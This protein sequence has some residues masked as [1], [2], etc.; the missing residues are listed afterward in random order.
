MSDIQFEFKP[1]EAELPPAPSITLS[2]DQKV[3]FDT[4]VER[5]ELEGEVSTLTGAAGCGKTTLMRTLIDHLVHQGRHVKLC[6]PTG[7]AAV[8]LSEVTGRGCETM[9][10]ALYMKVLQGQDKPVFDLPGPPCDPGDIVIIDEASMVARELYQEFQEWVPYESHVVYVGDKEQLPPV[11]DTWG[12]DLDNASAHLTEIHRQ[13]M[14]NPIIVFSKAVREGWDDRWEEEHF[15]PDDPRIQ[16][17]GGLNVAVDWLLDQRSR[18]EDAT[19]ITYTHN[20]RRRMNKAVRQ[21]LGLDVNMMSVGDKLVV[22]ANNPKVG[23]MNGEV[24]T[25]TEVDELDTYINFRVAESPF[26]LTM[27]KDLLEKPRGEFYKDTRHLRKKIP[28][29]VHI[30]YGQCLTV[31]SSQGSQWKNVGFVEGSAYKRLKRKDPDT[32]RRLKYTAITRAA[33][34]LAYI[35]S[36]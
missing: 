26:A 3:A 12:P 34:N 2:P 14:D 32:A 17:Y 18:E 1:P 33:E 36:A 4:L 6:T 7:K 21:K 22:K 5:T 10:K 30:H 28:H 8:R 29:L 25:V 11:N 13:A 16:A 27:K 9:H 35:M 31:H 19:L 23:L 20:I 15:D 24:V